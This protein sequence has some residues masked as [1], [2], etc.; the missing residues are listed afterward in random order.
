MNDFPKMHVSIE[1]H[2][3][4]RGSDGYNQTLSENRAGA[5]REYLEGRGIDPGRL[6]SVGYGETKPIAS[7]RT[8]RGRASNRRVEFKI[9]SE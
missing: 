9:V 8:A 3:D 1:G 5:V 7:N 6:K 2:T 4:D